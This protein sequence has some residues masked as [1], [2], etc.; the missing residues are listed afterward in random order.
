MT[1][2]EKILAL[3][4]LK[5]VQFD[6]QGEQTENARLTPLI[7]AL[8]DENEKLREALE[9]YASCAIEGLMEPPLG[10]EFMPMGERARQA[11][12]ASTAIDEMINRVS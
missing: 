4:E 10:M 7:T 11:L 1:R 5:T 6:T 12:S 2:R 9:F 8:I 3:C